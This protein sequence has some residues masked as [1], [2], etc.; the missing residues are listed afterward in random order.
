MSGRDIITIGA[1]AGGVEVLSEIVRGLPD[2][3]VWN[4]TA[5][6]EVDDHPVIATF[7]RVVPVQPLPQPM[8]ID[9]DNRVLLIVERG[10]PP[11]NFQGD[12]RF[13]DFV[14]PAEQHHVAQV[15]QQ[16]N[17]ASRMGK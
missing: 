5:G 8:R 3:E 12:C 4:I 15:L 1:S 6:R 16:L 13:F 2:D 10:G 17:A 11:E 7:G 9:S 14:L